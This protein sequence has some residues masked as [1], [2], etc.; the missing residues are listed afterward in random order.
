MKLID[1][2]LGGRIQDLAAPRNTMGH[3][4]PASLQPGSMALRST[5]RLPL[6][7]S[8]SQGSGQ[9]CTLKDIRKHVEA[10]IKG[11]DHPT[12]IVCTSTLEMGIDIGMVEST[13]QIGP[14]PSV[15]SMRQRLG[16]SGRRSGDATTRFCLCWPRTAVGGH[17]SCGIRFVGQAH[18]RR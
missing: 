17:P 11:K 7:A 2:Y 14:P 9:T 3:Q 10:Q 18:S 8:P 15:A 16:P 5:S 4:R 6:L 12:T 13:G 1:V